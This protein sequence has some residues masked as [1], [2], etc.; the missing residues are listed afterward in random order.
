[1]GLYNVKKA[2]ELQGGHI[3]FKT[4]LTGTTFIVSLP[5][6]AAAALADF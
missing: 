1:L 6:E 5:I 3:E 2:V 4:G